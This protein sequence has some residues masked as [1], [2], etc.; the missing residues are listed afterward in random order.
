MSS[1]LFTRDSATLSVNVACTDGESGNSGEATV[2][3][4]LATFRRVSTRCRGLQR[5]ARRQMA[6][7]QR[8]R[9]STKR[10]YTAILA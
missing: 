5:E 4:I 9:P 7:N 2:N 8:V 10:V 3:A 1:R 6:D